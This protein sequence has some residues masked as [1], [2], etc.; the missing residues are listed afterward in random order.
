TISAGG[1]PQWPQAYADAITWIV[2]QTMN[3]NPAGGKPD[4]AF[5]AELL[6]L[7]GE[8][9]LAEQLEVVDPDA[10]HAARNGLRRF[11]AETL[12]VPLNT[13]LHVL[14]PQGTFL[15]TTSEMGRRALRNICLGY[16]AELNT[17]EIRAQ[18]LA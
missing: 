5:A 3:K 7:P 13:L 14:E 15:P 16:L 1:Q 2:E 10:L 12:Q 4:W 8:A 9:T 17:A 11:M 6:S 18:A